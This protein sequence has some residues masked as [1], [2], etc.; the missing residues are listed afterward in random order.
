MRPRLRFEWR[1]LTNRAPWDSG[2]TPP[3]VERYLAGHAPGRAVEFGCGTGTNAIRLARAGWQVLAMDIS[4]L[5]I[6]AARRKARRAGQPITFL[7]ADVS[8]P[9]DLRSVLG[10]FDLALDIGCLHALS[11]AARQSYAGRLQDW[12]TPGADFLLYAFLRPGHQPDRWPTEAE[13]DGLFASGFQLVWK[14]HGEFDGAASA[15]FQFERM[16]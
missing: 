8:R 3:E 12:L 1:Y 15:W 6:S 4:A 14:E 5:A 2:V 13:L 7:R 10:P 11:P 16:P 9:D